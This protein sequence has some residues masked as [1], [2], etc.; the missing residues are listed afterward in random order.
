MM[1]GETVDRGP[2]AGEG[3]PPEEPRM[4]LDVAPIGPPSFDAA[5]DAAPRVR[6]TAAADSVAISSGVVPDSPPP[7]VLDAIGAAGRAY[8]DLQAHGRELR[9]STDGEQGVSVEVTDLDGNVL[10][11]LSPSAA[12]DVAAGGAVDR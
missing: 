7:E 1:P 2:Q 10:R 6:R 4:S 5:Q 12:L 9:F 11:T 3:R 8:Q